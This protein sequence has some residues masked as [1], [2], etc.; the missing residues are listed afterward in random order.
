[1]LLAH[2]WVMLRVRKKSHQEIHKKCNFDSQNFFQFNAQLSRIVQCLIQFTVERK[3]NQAHGVG[4]HVVGWRPETEVS[5]RPKGRLMN[6]R[7]Q[8]RVKI[9]PETIPSPKFEII[10]EESIWL[11]FSRARR[12]VQGKD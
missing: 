9:M 7:L 5:K 11:I 10:Q 4:L 1:M 6:K 3:F 12:V 8:I 2:V